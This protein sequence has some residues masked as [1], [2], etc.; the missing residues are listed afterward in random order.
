VPKAQTAAACYYQMVPVRIRTKGWATM[1]RARRQV[2]TSTELSS[3]LPAAAPETSVGLFATCA[4]EALPSSRTRIDVDACS[5]S[6]ME[7]RRLK[8][9]SQHLIQVRTHC[10]ECSSKGL[11]R[12]GPQGRFKHSAIEWIVSCRHFHTS[13]AVCWGNSFDEDVTLLE[14]NVDDFITLFAKATSDVRIL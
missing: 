14:R 13:I 7:S 4:C 8:K 12:Q 6:L 10:A 1:D 5:K 2:Y 11:T 3:Q 9:C